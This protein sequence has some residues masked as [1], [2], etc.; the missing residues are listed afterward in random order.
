MHENCYAVS[1][2][3][4]ESKLINDV[5]GKK[6]QDLQS[7]CAHVGRYDFSYFQKDESPQRWLTESQ[8]QA[9]AVFLCL[10]PFSQTCHGRSQMP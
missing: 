6:R 5:T 2:W 10:F 7:S 1:G 9:V 8:E 3:L 4:W